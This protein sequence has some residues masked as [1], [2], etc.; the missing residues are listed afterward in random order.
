MS[1]YKVLQPGPSF[2]IDGIFMPASSG[3][4]TLEHYASV[5]DRFF[6]IFPEGKTILV[7][8]R[9]PNALL[10]LFRITEKAHDHEIRGELFEGYEF[11]AVSSF[12]IY[13]SR[14]L[15]GDRYLM[16][17]HLLSYQEGPNVFNVFHVMSEETLYA[18]SVWRTARVNRWHID[19]VP[20]D[21]MLWSPGD[22]FI[23]LCGIRT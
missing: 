16:E 18:V 13:L 11:Q 20:L 19:A 5:T 3:S 4:G 10:Q 8:K 1:E 6:A 17:R 7:A 14:L 23:A 12:L 22:Q 9:V 2:E 15:W 21:T